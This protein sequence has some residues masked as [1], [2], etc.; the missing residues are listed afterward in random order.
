MPSSFELY[1][2]ASTPFYVE[3]VAAHPEPQELVQGVYDRGLNRS[4]TYTLGQMSIDFGGLPITSAIAEIYPEELGY[5]LPAFYSWTNI[6]QKMTF[7]FI[8]RMQTTIRPCPPAL[9]YFVCSQ[10][11]MEGVQAYRRQVSIL[12]MRRGQLV[13]PT[14]GQLATYAARELRRFMVGRSLL[15]FSGLC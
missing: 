13:P 10:F 9:T 11:D 5:E 14:R 15:R 6:P 2:Q 7:M 1:I 8:V 3:G 4:R 12:R